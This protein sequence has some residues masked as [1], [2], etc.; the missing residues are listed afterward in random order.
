[1]YVGSA[2][3]SDRTL[4][5]IARGKP[6]PPV[7]LVSSPSSLCITPRSS[8]NSASTSSEIDSVVMTTGRSDCPQPIVAVRNMNGPCQAAAACMVTAAS[9]W[10]AASSRWRAAS[11]RCWAIAA[12]CSAS[13]AP[14][15]PGGPPRAPGAAGGAGGAGGA[16]GSTGGASASG[17]VG[18]FDCAHAL[19]VRARANVAAMILLRMVRA[20]RVSALG[21]SVLRRRAGQA[22]ERFL[23]LQ[24][25]GFD[26][27][28]QP[29]V[30]RQPLLLELADAIVHLPQERPLRRLLLGRVLRE[31]GRHLLLHVGANLLEVR[32]RWRGQPRDCKARRD[33]HERGRRPL[34]AAVDRKARPM[35]ARAPLRQLPRRQRAAGLAPRINSLAALAARI[36]VPRD[37]CLFGGRELFVD[38]SNKLFATWVVHGVVHVVNSSSAA[39]RAPAASVVPPAGPAR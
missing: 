24:G 20:P 3:A 39:L 7:R 35:R 33:E 6:S 34:H 1:M 23:R 37:L 27:V 32:H 10:R 29:P 26:V 38:E 15:S 17:C 22:H 30:V 19:P 14:Y 31:L 28:A 2:N 13:A 25:D 21:R 8:F 4:I 11:S 16:V 18:V 12:R 5:P 9:R 36:D